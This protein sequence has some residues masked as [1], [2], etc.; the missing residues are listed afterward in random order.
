MQRK[1]KNKQT[2][3]QKGI[4][5]SSGSKRQTANSTDIMQSL[6]TYNKTDSLHFNAFFYSL[7]PV[8]L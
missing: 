5:H 3:K 4:D 6:Q 7:S 1:D 8:K 2:N